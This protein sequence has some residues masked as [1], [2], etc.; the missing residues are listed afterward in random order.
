MRC[1]AAVPQVYYLGKVEGTA[2]EYVVDQVDRYCDHCM[3]HLP[4]GTLLT[5]HGGQDRCLDCYPVSAE[6]AQDVTG[7]VARAM[8][9]REGPWY[10]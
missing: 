9:D 4:A 5:E 6:I 8:K 2:A 1:V 3:A 7:W 10:E